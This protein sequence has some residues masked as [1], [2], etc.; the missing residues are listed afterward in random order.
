MHTVI[1]YNKE[2]LSQPILFK[3]IILV[4][5]FEVLKKS[6]VKR[7]QRRFVRNTRHFNIL[8]TC[9]L[10]SLVGRIWPTAVT[11]GNLR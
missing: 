11:I 4:T 8:Y 1:S 3:H 9:G 2:L 6:S 10:L 7:I 5:L